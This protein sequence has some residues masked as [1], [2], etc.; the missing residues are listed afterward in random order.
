MYWLLDSE[1][2]KYILRTRPHPSR[3]DRQTTMNALEEEEAQQ[4]TE[5]TEKFDSEEEV[6]Y[7][8]IIT[9]R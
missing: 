4:E 6:K 3:R 9:T 5:V 7:Y 8:S 1:K 2:S